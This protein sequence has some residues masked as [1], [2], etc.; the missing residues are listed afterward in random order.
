MSDRFEYK[1]A[2]ADIKGMGL[3]VKPETYR[4]R[5]MDLLNRLGREGWDCYHVKT[6]EFPALYYMKRKV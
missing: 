2:Q 1:I 6:D 4:A 5:E 3:V